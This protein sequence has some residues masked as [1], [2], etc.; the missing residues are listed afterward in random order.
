MEAGPVPAPTDSG[1]MTA[2]AYGVPAPPPDLTPPSPPP[3]GSATPN[4]AGSTGPQ[5]QPPKKK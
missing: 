1:M 2:P 4:A 3:S 5:K